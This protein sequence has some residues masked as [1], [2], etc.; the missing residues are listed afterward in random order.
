[1]HN[2]YIRSRKKKET[3]EIFDTIMTANFPH[4][5]VRRHTTNPENSE[6][7]KQD[8]CQETSTR[9]IIFKLRKIKAKENKSL[10]KARGKNL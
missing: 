2:E 6:D 8:K 3:E 4:I 1:M 9:Q 5:N 10:K 7:T